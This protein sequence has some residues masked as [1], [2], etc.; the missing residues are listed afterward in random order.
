MSGGPT[1]GWP[2]YVYYWHRG[3]VG[4]TKRFP[5]GWPGFIS[6]FAVEK[7]WAIADYKRLYDNG[8]AVFKKFVL[9]ERQFKKNWVEWEKML[10][11]FF[12]LKKE[13]AAK[14][15]TR[16]DKKQLADL[17]IRWNDFYAGDFWNVGSLPEVA[18]WGGEQLLERE[19]KK[20]LKNESDFHLAME[21]L[22]AS[23]DYSFY[24]KEELALLKFKAVKNKKQ[25]TEKLA[26]HQK[27]YFWILNSYYG[28]KVLPVSY[29]KK[30]LSS[31][32]ANQAINKIR[33]I[34]ELRLRSIGL[35]QAI[36]KK[37]GLPK[38]ILMIARRLAYSIWWQDLRKSYIF[39]ANYIIDLLLSKVAKIFKID[40]NDLHYYSLDELENLVLKNR[41]VSKAE[42]KKRQ[43]NFFIYLNP[44]VFKETHFSGKVAAKLARPYLERKIDGNIKEFK[45]LVVNRGKVRGKARILLSSSQAG[46][47]KIGEILV[48]PMTSPEYIT[49]LRK[50]AA[51]ITDEGG[52]TCH[53]AIV[54]RELGIPAIV[55]TKIATKVLRDGDLVEVDANYGVVKILK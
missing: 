39:Q 11:S 32:S 24:Q 38:N 49:A 7:M 4:C 17:I 48:A 31:V 34:K 6:Y 5:P 35:K 40:F 1:D 8:E 3:F 30:R 13:V 2:I 55:G 42:I 19:L 27:N 28:T 44:K 23:E 12:S 25:L 33:Q 22:T 47:M 16:L 10:T 51:V 9:N 46:K 21:R 20:S 50:A 37:L 29:F 15:K 53:A 52:I 45:G 41:R 14:V 26:E 36:I 43:K 54:S 18:N